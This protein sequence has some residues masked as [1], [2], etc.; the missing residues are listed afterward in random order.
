M[1]RYLF[2]TL[3]LLTLKVQSQEKSL[4]LVAKVEPHRVILRWMPLDYKT[5][6]EG[7]EKG[8]DIYRYEAQDSLGT[9]KRLNKQTIRPLPNAAWN[10][11]SSYA[12]V[13]KKIQEKPYTADTTQQNLYLALA[14][15]MSNMEAD[16]AQAM[17]QYFIDSTIATNRSYAYLV[18]MEGGKIAFTQKVIPNE[19]TILQAPKLLESTYKDST[20]NFKWRMTDPL[21]QSAF[22][23]EMSDNSQ[24]TWR[25]TTDAP[26]VAGDETDDAGNILITYALKAPKFYHPYYF[27][28]RAITPFGQLSE[29][30]D[31]T[32]LYAFR[33]RLPQ[34]Q[35][36]HTINTE[37]Q[38][39]LS[40]VFPDSLNFD[41]RGFAIF[42]SDKPDTNFVEYT[43]VKRELR[44][45]TDKK[46][47]TEGYYKLAIADWEGNNHFSLAQ[48][49]QLEDSIP[50][51]QPLWKTSEIAPNGG[52]HLSWE[53]NK[54][55]DLAGY[56]IYYADSPLA[57]FSVLTPTLSK[58]STFS[59]SVALN[60]L[61]KKLYYTL[62]AVD[63]RLNVSKP[64][65]TLV[66]IRPDTL[67]PA[68][69]NFTHFELSDTAVYLE[70][71]NSPSIDL[72]YTLLLRRS[73]KDTA[74]L[75]LAKF[76]PE[77][78]MKS[79]LD[80]TAAENTE[81][82]YTLL[83]VDLAGLKADSSHIR[84]ASTFSGIRKAISDLKFEP[85]PDAN[86][87]KITW[88]IP[89]RKVKK[90]TL[91]RQGPADGSVTPYQVFSGQ[92]GSYLDQNLSQ[93]VPYKYRIMALFEDNSRSQ[94]SAVF[95]TTLP[96]K[97]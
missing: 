76:D 17:G 5:W 58:D 13:V 8:Y 22:V 83:P 43:R 68:A 63:L 60:L 28:I 37:G 92:Y 42:R 95:T 59:T 79:F 30:S 1:K 39:E 93:N 23:V 80:S 34:A 65:D 96:T 89:K 50:P 61:N 88:P 47:L 90:Y 14:L 45:Y 18:I 72:A 4:G 24:R 19:Y 41:I 38:V 62:V 31:T 57:E 91:Y 64:A 27:R 12:Q 69:A 82:V 84:L 54:E 49:V 29:P 33:D 15:Q 94:I 78:S 46:P 73:V 3:M 67:A 87:I 25:P 74:R 7:T 36:K 35:L 2:I 81:Y 44:S 20:F 70:W 40:W 11:H 77:H 32:Y 9:V 75:I 86:T 97:K 52:V 53:A 85:D 66:L 51:S 56:R 10:T 71:A 48:F 16:I 55:K 6:Q 26:I 21:L